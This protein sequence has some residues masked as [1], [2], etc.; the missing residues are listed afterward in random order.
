MKLR[1]PTRRRIG[2]DAPGAAM[3]EL[4]VFVTVIA[5]TLVLSFVFI[6]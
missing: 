2:A 1:T 6:A 3:S 4:A 5:L